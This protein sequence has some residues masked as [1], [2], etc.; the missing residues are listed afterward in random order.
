MTSLQQDEIRLHPILV[1]GD[2]QTPQGNRPRDNAYQG[3]PCRQI[4]EGEELFIPAPP[5]P[6]SEV[7]PLL[8]SQPVS[9]PRV[10]ALEGGT[11]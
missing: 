5:P 11:E 1:P 10:P 3:L 7:N 2:R 6:G 8:P 4:L 9:N